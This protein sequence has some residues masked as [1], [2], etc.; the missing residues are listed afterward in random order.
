MTPRP[1]FQRFIGRCLLLALAL[2]L[3]VLLGVAAARAQQAPQGDVRQRQKEL[4]ELRARIEESRKRAASLADDEKQQLRRLKALEQEA[5]DTQRLLK[6]L[7]ARERDLNARVDRLKSRLA[8]SDSSMAARRARLAAQLRNMYKRSRASRPLLLEG[9]VDMQSL[10]RR[11]RA[12]TALARSERTFLERTRAQRDEL[13]RRRQE[14]DAVLAEVYRNRSQVAEQSARLLELEEE[15]K[16]SLEAVHAERS[17]WE[18]S[19]RELEKSAAALEEL[20]ARLE[21]QRK[22]GSSAPSTGFSALKGRLPWPVRGKVTQRFGKH[23]HPRFKTVVVNKGINI[24]ATEGSPIRAVAAGTVDYV[25]WLPGYGKCIILNHGDGWY[26]L[27][28][29]AREIFPAVGATVLAQEV[30]AEVG[31]TGSLDGSQLYFEIRHGKEPVDPSR[32]LSR[33]RRSARR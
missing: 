3:A 4:A 6:K 10:A 7:E 11:V 24:A 21:R 23:I 2:A 33:S 12:L 29:H 18:A 22:R 31:D 28:A 8:E 30:I 5:K 27:Y 9:S 14:L 19:A 25:N 32:W 1:F 17:R 15:R 26:T 16:K 20:L 13:A